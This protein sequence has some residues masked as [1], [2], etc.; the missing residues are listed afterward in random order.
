MTRL[1]SIPALIL[2]TACQ[3]AP[4]EAPAAPLFTLQTVDD[5]PFPARATLRLEDRRYSGAGPCN[6]FGGTLERQEDGLRFGQME[7]TLVSCPDD[8][9]EARYF[10]LLRAVVRARETGN[11]LVLSTETGHELVFARNGP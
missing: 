4:P 2:L 9:H 8:V 1:L 11:R 5:R 6:G 7:S 3:A 10:A